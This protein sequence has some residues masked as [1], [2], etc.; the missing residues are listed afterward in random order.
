MYTMDGQPRKA[1]TSRKRCV[2]PGNR[3]RDVPRGTGGHQAD[4]V[5][6]AIRKQALG[7]SNK[8]DGEGGDGGD[9]VGPVSLAEASSEPEPPKRGRSM[10]RRQQQQQQQ[11]HQQRVAAK[12]ERLVH[13]EQVKH[14]L[15][16]LPPPSVSRVG[17]EDRIG[18]GL[19]DIGGKEHR[20]GTQKRHRPGARKASPEGDGKYPNIFFLKTLLPCGFGQ[21]E[22]FSGSFSN[23][24]FREHVPN[25]AQGDYFL[26][27][28]PGLMRAWRMFAM[29]GPSARRKK[30][31]LVLV[32]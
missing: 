25:K 21:T 3:T 22:A 29:E 12:P 23:Q 17:G 7:R 31:R 14:G 27:K 18:R 11:Q 2:S 8:A 16:H 5:L 1:I 13:V 24:N 10:G 4:A 9:D 19:S 6:D 26:G 20:L 32:H 30:V 15:E 28:R